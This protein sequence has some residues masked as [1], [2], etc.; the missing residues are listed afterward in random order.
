ML[1]KVG[2]SFRFGT[3]GSFLAGVS[4][5]VSIAETKK[6]SEESKESPYLISNKASI[7]LNEYGGENST[8]F[9]PSSDKNCRIF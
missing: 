3:D 9:S 5:G 1:E 7:L 6:T 4:S 2:A 8:I